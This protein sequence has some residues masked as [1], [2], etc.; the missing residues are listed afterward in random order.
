METSIK[1]RIYSTIGMLNSYTI[2]SV[3]ESDLLKE[4]NEYKKFS[5]IKSKNQVH[6]TEKYNIRAVYE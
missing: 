4:T 5:T 3:C 2:Q 1:E 6:S